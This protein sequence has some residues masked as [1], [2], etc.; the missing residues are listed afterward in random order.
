MSQQGFQDALAALVND[1]NYREKVVGNQAALVKDFD[2][3]PGEIGLLSAVGEACG[4]FPE[5]KGYEVAA[6]ESLDGI[7]VIIICCC[8][9]P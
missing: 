7:D 9:C 8:C 2:L 6:A 1:P 5:V 3:S 4:G